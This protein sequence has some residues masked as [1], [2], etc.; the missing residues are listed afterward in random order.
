MIFPRC[1]DGRTVCC[2]SSGSA[3]TAEK[4]RMHLDGYRRTVLQ[5]P[6]RGWGF[7]RNLGRMSLAKIVPLRTVPWRFVRFL[8]FRRPTHCFHA[9]DSGT[10]LCMGPAAAAGITRRGA[11][12]PTH[13][14]RHPPSIEHMRSRISARSERISNCHIASLP[15]HTLATAHGYPLSCPHARFTRSPRT[16]LPFSL[17]RAAH[18]LSGSLRRI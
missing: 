10:N 15:H 16:A 7:A 5:Y 1:E 11:E 14:H 12:P 4:T 3:L 9:L 8:S 13:A 18:R 2:A 6:G 17:W